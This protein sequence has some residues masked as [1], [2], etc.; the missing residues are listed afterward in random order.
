MLYEGVKMQQ[1]VRISTKEF[2]K[3]LSKG[4]GRSKQEFNS[5]NIFQN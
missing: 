5:V 2:V 4:F 1:G 3:M